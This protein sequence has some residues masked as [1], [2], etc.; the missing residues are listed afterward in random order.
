MAAPFRVCSAGAD[1][2]PAVGAGLAAGI[3]DEPGRRSRR[4]G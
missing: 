2:L 1:E 4:A 3:E